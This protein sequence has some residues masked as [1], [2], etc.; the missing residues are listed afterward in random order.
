MAAIIPIVSAGIQMSQQKAQSDIAVGESNLKAEQQELGAKQ[1]EADR[2]ERL[3]VALASQNAMAGS[4]G[5]AAFE[6]SPL[7]IM[8]EDFRREKQATEQ[9]AFST[10][11]EAMTSRSRGKV[12]KKSSG[13]KSLIAGGEAVTKVIGAQ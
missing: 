9:D 5:I 6:G 13:S 10:K 8:K 12:F 3:A 1:R 4:G 11:I 7:T 2:K